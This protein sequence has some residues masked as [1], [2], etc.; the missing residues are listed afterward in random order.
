MKHPFIN[1]GLRGALYLGGALPVIFV[2]LILAEQLLGHQEA[3]ASPLSLVLAASALLLAGGLWGRSLARQA[4]AGRP[5]LLM[6]ATAVTFAGATVGAVLGLGVLENVFVEQGRAGRIPVYIV[7]A[8]LFSLANVLAFGLLAVVA[9]A[10]IRG[11]R[12]A[13]RLAVTAGPAAGAAFL[14]ADVLQDVLGRRVGGVRA[15]ETFT[16]LS[17]A[18]I[19]NLVAAFAGSGVLGLLLAGWRPAQPV[20]PESAAIP[21]GQTP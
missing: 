3:G 5:R 8:I 10:V 16:M 12:F 15:E 20:Q 13:A 4:G 6:A 1:Y 9:G 14:L 18:L 7:F 19:G 11:W 21:Q 17:V 2:A